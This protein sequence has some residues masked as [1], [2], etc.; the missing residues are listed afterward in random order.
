ME[1]N[2]IMYKVIFKFLDNLRVSGIIN[3]SEAERDIQDRYNLPKHIARQYL[4]LWSETFDKNAPMSS[5]VTKALE[6]NKKGETC[7]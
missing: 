1:T 2:P 6:I 4:T 3:M 5:R 7:K